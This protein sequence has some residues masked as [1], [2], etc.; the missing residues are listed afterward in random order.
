MSELTTVFLN[1]VPLSAKTLVLALILSGASASAKDPFDFNLSASPTQ[2]PWQVSGYLES[3]NQYF[4]VDD[5]WASNR[6]AGSV[7]L[8]WEG[9]SAEDHQWRAYGSAW[10]EHD[11]QTREYRDP[12]RSELKEFYFLRDGS[13]IDLTIGKQRVAWGT[14]D[15]VST[16]DRV[17]A[18]DLRDPIG[19]AR[20][21]SRRPS[22]VVRNEIDLSKGIL[23]LVWLP[24]GRDRKLAEF[25]SPWEP[26]DLH[27]LRA[28]QAAGL[29]ELH[30]DDPHKNEGGIRYLAYGQGFDWSV[31]YFNGYTDA[32]LRQTGTRKDIRLEPIR[33]ETFNVSG[34]RGLAQSTLRAE[35]AYTPNT[36]VSGQ[37]TDVWQAIVGWD[38]TFFTNLYASLQFFYDAAPDGPNAYGTTFA[39]SNTAFDDAGRYG[40]R[41]QFEND[42]QLVAELY[43][44]YDFGDDLDL[45]I[46]YLIFDAAA[47]SES[48]DYRDNDFFQAI[49]RWDL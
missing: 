13:N 2:D 44:D 5:D 25:D 36:I 40:L 15:G 19:N 49:L 14:T 26:A 29:L 18:V 34:A 41:G 21:A 3:R 30:I 8:K 33:V 48:F 31:A 4:V 42:E 17:N 9:K 16:I 7:E 46:K 45:G 28:L 12:K 27:A 35:V 37:V 6:V 24:R 43:F 38:R 23:D 1:K 10:V 11:Q 39:L 22:W 32:P 20:T 47:G